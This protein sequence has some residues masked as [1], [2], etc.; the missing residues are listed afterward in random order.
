MKMMHTLVFTALA[1]ISASAAAESTAPRPLR[2][3]EMVAYLES[4]NAGEVVGIELD[5]SGDKRPHYHV[6]LWYP[7]LGLARYDVDAVTGDISAHDTGGPPSGAATL[8]EATALIAAQLPGQL[9][10]VELDTGDGAP[11]HY[12]VDMRVAD[13]KIARL[14]VDAATRSIGWRQPAIV[15]E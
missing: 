4:N 14:K 5:G 1:A 8:Y 10:H 13:G 11:A 7:Q 9:I 15:D 6:D 3:A 12:D 2:L